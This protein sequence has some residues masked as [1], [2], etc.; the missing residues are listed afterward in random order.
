MVSEEETR[1]LI[2]QFR[3]NVGR[4]IVFNKNAFEYFWYKDWEGLE[5]EIVEQDVPYCV[6]FKIVKGCKVK[7][8]GN[9]VSW[10]AEFGHCFDILEEVN[11]VIPENNHPC[12]KCKSLD[13]KGLSRLDCVIKGTI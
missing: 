1:E 7:S 8:E 4:R 2:K 6:K 13:C 9:I 12:P 3:N 10:D 11:F 5:G